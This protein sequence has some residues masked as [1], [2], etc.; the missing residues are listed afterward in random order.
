M[1]RDMIHANH[2]SELFDAGLGLVI[3]DTSPGRVTIRLP[4]GEERA[5]LAGDLAHIRTVPAELYGLAVTAYRVE[6]LPPR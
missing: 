1:A 2:S 4:R 6:D 3:F 5:Y